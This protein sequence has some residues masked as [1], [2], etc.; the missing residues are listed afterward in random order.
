M[1]R[2]SFITIFIILF[3]FSCSNKNKLLLKKI[4]INSDYEIDILNYDAQTNVY[5]WLLTENY[6][7]GRMKSYLATAKKI[8]KDKWLIYKISFNDYCSR[9]SKKYI[10]F[11]DECDRSSWGWF[12]LK[13]GK[14]SNELPNINHLRDSIDKA[15]PT[16]I[17]V[18]ENNGYI[19][20]LKN[21]IVVTEINY[22]NIVT[23]YTQLNFDSLDHLLYKLDGD[24][25]KVVSSNIHDVTRQKDGIYFVPAPGYFIARKFEKKK[26][27]QLVDSVSKLSHPPGLIKVSDE[28]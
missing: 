11:T 12:A 13:N 17:F 21:G 27:Y 15:A 28:N 9:N 10:A 14:I 26:I 22:G 6:T 20:K 19:S 16:G 2:I 18:K 23:K 8:S 25:I 24:S 1:K 4:E 3:F 5:I 7:F